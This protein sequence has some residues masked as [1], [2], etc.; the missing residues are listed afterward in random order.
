MLYFLHFRKLFD[1]AAYGDVV[2][3]ASQICAATERDW[4]IYVQNSL[5]LPPHGLKAA[6]SPCHFEIVYIHREVEP[7]LAVDVQAFP[8]FDFFRA[9]Q[10]QRSLAMPLPAQTCQRMAVQIA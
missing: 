2:L 5:Y 6:L 10:K 7:I 9:Y 8:T 3:S 1:A 4:W